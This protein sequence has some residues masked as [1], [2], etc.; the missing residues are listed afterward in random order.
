MSQDHESNDAPKAGRSGRRSDGLL[1]TGDMARLTGNTLR[2][3]RFYEEAQILQPD[4]RSAGG[5]RLFSRRQLDRLQFITDMRAT[6]LSLEE[7]RALLEL[8]NSATTGGQAAA[9]A[10]EAIDGQVTVLEQKIAVFTRL[11]DELSRAREILTECKKCANETCFPDACGACDVISERTAVPQSMRV[12][13]G[14]EPRRGGST[15]VTP[16]EDAADVG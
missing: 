7:I 4:R 15:K 5:H 10:L 2:T 8:K 12:L 3:V 1:T 13:W 14:I 6:G 11:R 9:S 16:D